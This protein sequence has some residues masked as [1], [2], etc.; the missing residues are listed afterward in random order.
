[1]TDCYL[2]VKTHN[3][4]GLKYLG[5]TKK[6]DPHKYTGSGKK[7]LMHLKK[8]GYDYTTEILLVTKDDIELKET[9]IFFSKLWNIVESKEWANL[10]EESGDGGDTSSSEGYIIGIRNRDITKERN[11]M[12]GRSAITEKN[13]KWYTNGFKNVYLTEG[14]E[15]EGFLRGRSNL[16]RKPHSKEHRMKIS[17]SLKGRAAH[18]RKE[19]I[20]PNGMQ[21]KSIKEAANYC[22]LTV[23]QFKHR[24]IYN[25][26]W[27]VK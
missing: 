12:H 23:S 4:T 17:E 27:T 3:K 20:S 10:R 11:P 6:L 16:K 8:H 7:W 13:L 15:P 5:K 18:N 19:V 25:G 21:F 1:M 9:G 14:T 26:S 24:M 2:Y 22:D